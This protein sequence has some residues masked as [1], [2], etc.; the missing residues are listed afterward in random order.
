VEW[1]R[2]ESEMKGE[3][4]QELLYIL[5]GFAE[6]SKTSARYRSENNFAYCQNDF[7]ERLNEQYRKSFDILTDG[8]NVLH[9]YFDESNKIIL[10][11]Y[12]VK[13]LDTSLS[14]RM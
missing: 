9:N 8:L 1:K 6:V 2:I 5:H 3:F 4:L 11:L 10:D 13:F 7:I 12:L 14:F